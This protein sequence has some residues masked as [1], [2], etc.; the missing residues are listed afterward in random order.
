MFQPPLIP[1]LTTASGAVFDRRCTGL[2]AGGRRVR[3]VAVVRGVAERERA[4][5]V[6]PRADPARARVFVVVLRDLPAMD[7]G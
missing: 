5:V 6:R 3:G 2:R 4:A 1:R 7:L